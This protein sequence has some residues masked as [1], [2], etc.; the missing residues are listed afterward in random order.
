MDGGSV[1][2]AQTP[3]GMHFMPL[4][5]FQSESADSTT[6]DGC[7]TPSER[8]SN[9]SGEQNLSN[10]KLVFGLMERGLPSLERGWRTPDPSPTRTGLPKCAAFTEFIEETEDQNQPTPRRERGR[11]PAKQEE[12][13][14]SPSPAQ[15]PW[16]RLQTPSPEPALPM[17]ALPQDFMSSF[18]QQAAPTVA[19]EPRN[20]A[21]IIDN[22]VAQD[23][24]P[25]SQETNNGMQYPL[26]VSLG[27]EGHPF[28]CG[29]ACKYAS[30]GKGCKDGAN[31]DHCHLCKWKK[32][33]PVRPARGRAPKPGNRRGKQAGN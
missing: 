26:C 14:R 32:A 16:L 18:F 1:S 21:D 19:P 20:W 29:P 25:E 31:C 6:D 10:L 30:K 12:K 17:P 13:G 28:S 33:A 8:D 11:Q 9:H 24:Q 22:T 3:E 4:L 5:K 7:R 23:E 27:S 15:Q 2:R